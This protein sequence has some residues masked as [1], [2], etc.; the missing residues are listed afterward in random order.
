[1]SRACGGVLEHGGLH[2]VDVLA[3]T[4]AYFLSVRGDAAAFGDVP[5][6]TACRTV[7]VSLRCAILCVL[8]RLSGCWLCVTMSIAV[9][10]RSGPFA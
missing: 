5:P 1:M 9:Y 2:T 3:N 4:L 8:R 7:A 6:A 10:L